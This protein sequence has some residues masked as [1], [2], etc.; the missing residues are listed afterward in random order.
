MKDL[1]QDLRKLDEQLQRNKDKLY[2]E[3]ASIKE[4][5]ILQWIEENV[6][7]GMIFWFHGYII[8]EELEFKKVDGAKIVFWNK[9]FNEED[10]F[11]PLGF[12]NL[13]KEEFDEIGNKTTIRK[14]C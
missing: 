11:T 5:L 7:E 14:M 10:I 8:S 1:K 3:Y 2:N 4:H 12:L 6:K 13:E 9:T